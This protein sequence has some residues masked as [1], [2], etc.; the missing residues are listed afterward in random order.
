MLKQNWKNAIFNWC[1]SWVRHVRNYFTYFLNQWKTSC[2]PC[3][4]YLSKYFTLDFGQAIVYVYVFSAMIYHWSAVSMLD[5]LYNVLNYDKQ[6]I[7]WKVRNHFKRI[8]YWY[9]PQR[10]WSNSKRRQQSSCDG[11][12][13]LSH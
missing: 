13:Y 8:D 4:T 1:Q 9:T 5:H 2:T 3:I 11:Y 6:R 7:Y 12:V 10:R